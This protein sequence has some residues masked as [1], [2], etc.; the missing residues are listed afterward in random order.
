MTR[1]TRN[2]KNRSINPRGTCHDSVYT[3][4]YVAVMMNKFD[5]GMTVPRAKRNK[6]YRGP[7]VS[8][9]MRGR[10]LGLYVELL[11]AKREHFARRIGGGFL[12]DRGV[13]RDPPAEPD[14][15]DVQVLDLRNLPAGGGDIVLDASGQML[16]ANDPRRR[17]IQWNTVTALQS[18]PEGVTEVDPASVPDGPDDVIV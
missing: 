11:A 9:R 2:G 17:E 4:G 8:R 13:R 1:L 3:D 18:T 10:D 15:G 14:T 5:K 12:Y 6:G 16:P 7:R